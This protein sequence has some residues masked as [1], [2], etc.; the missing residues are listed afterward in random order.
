MKRLYIREEKI[1]LRPENP[2]YQ[3]IP[4]GSDDDP[5]V[6]GKVVGVRRLGWDKRP[7]PNKDLE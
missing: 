1:E 3:P 6:L 4:I 5:R 2:K 7:I